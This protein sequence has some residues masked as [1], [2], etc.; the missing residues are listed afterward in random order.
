MQISPPVPG[1]SGKGEEVQVFTTHTQA[2]MN[3]ADPLRFCVLGNR[4]KSTAWCRTKQFEVIG[5]FLKQRGVFRDENTHHV[6]GRVVAGD[7]NILGENVT[8]LTSGS[9]ICDGDEYKASPTEEY[10]SMIKTLDCGG[11][12][13]VTDVWRDLNPLPSDNENEKS[14]VLSRNQLG[15]TC[16]GS[17]NSDV[18]DHE[19][20]KRLDFVMMIEEISPNPT[21]GTYGSVG[22]EKMAYGAVNRDAAAGDIR[23]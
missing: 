6:I 10:C 2:D 3:E 9:N 19:E 15:L 16:D 22:G 14:K 23:R 12:Y 1:S 17:R 20:E 4:D 5:S 21:N 18:M 13:S 8:R 7:F 11:A